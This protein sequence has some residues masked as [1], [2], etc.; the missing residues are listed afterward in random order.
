MTQA[1]SATSATEFL[2]AEGNDRPEGFPQWLFFCRFRKQ[3]TPSF[4]VARR[5][6]GSGWVR[7]TSMTA[8]KR[9]LTKMMAERDW[10]AAG[11]RWQGK[12]TT[13]RLVGWSRQRRV[14]LMRRKLDW[15]LGMARPDYGRCCIAWGAA[16]GRLC[17]AVMWRGVS[18]R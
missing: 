3:L 12:E 16:V 4:A 2:D 5:R 13:L 10:T 9:A 11:H 15:P 17:C 14:V 18:N 8:V 7:S 6:A 1:V